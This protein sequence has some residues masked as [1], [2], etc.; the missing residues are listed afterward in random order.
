MTHDEKTKAIHEITGLTSAF[1][2]A[3]IVLT[4]NRLNLFT[5]LSGKKLTAEKLAQ[6]M[7]T[8]P[9]ATA[10]LCNALTALGFLEKENDQYQNSAKSDLHLVQGQPYFIGDQLRHQTRLWQSWSKLEDAV[11]TGEPVPNAESSSEKNQQ[12]ARKFTLAMANIGQL[13]ARQVVEGLDL[14]GVR[15]M[16]DLG[17]GPG[18]Y[19]L[20]FVKKNPNIHAVIFD[21]PDVVV[22][23][24]ERLQQ[25]EYNDRI[26]TKPGDALEDDLGSGYDLAFMSNFIHILSYDRI[27]SVFKR[28][29]KALSPSGRI[30]VKDFF[31]NEDRSGPVFATQFALNMLLNTEGGNTYT[32]SEILAAFE[33]TGFQWLNSFQVGGHSTVIVA[34]KTK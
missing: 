11:K 31:V 8:E 19:A 5:H 30:V 34:E 26:S 32:F 21:L 3:Q 2:P 22:V 15:K 18:A 6:E 28:V 24:E 29:S 33:K 16:I 12:R 9:R 10:M 23:A 7:E 13:S 17:G 27:I 1:M 4:A 14:R 25:T 20:E